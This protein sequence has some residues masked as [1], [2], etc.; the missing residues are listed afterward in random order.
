M[1]LE[2]SMR[3]ALRS[4]MPALAAANAWDLSLR[5]FMWRRTW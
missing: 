2:L 5:C 4:L 3:C 1:V